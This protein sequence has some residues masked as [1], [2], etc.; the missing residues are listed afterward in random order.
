M[1]GTQQFEKYKDRIITDDYRKWDF[2]HLIIETAKM[3][4][5]TFYKEFYKLYV[6]LALLILRNR[7][8][9]FKY[10]KAAIGASFN[11]WLEVLK[12]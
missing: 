12:G 4:K 5:L 1:P 7:I 3:S 10:I 2:I 11:Y 8:L 9:S 6:K